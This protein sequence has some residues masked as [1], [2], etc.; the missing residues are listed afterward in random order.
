MIKAVFWDFGGVIT[1][2]PFESFNR[3]ENDINCVIDYITKCDILQNRCY[4][5]DTYSYTK[6]MIINCDKSFMEFEGLRHPLIERLNTNE[7]IYPNTE[8]EIGTLS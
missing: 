5:A 6:P 8:D 7:I 4:I 2:S 1:S 3:Y